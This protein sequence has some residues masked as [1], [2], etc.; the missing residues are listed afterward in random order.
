MI[1][2]LGAKLRFCALDCDFVRL[3]CVSAGL[4]VHY[5]ARR[6]SFFLSWTHQFLRPISIC[7]NKVLKGIIAGK[8]PVSVRT[9]KLRDKAIVRGG[10][11]GHAPGPR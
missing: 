3:R 11:N 4:L 1:P 2:S 8:T 7:I 5:V 9:K 6:P 10:D